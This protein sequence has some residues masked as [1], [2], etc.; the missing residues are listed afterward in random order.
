VIEHRAA[1]DRA[2][3][4]FQRRRKN[5][6]TPERCTHL[7]EYIYDEIDERPVIYVAGEPLGEYA[8]GRVES[9]VIE[10]DAEE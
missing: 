2:I 1:V 7:A 10:P 4:R 9:L 5:N 8:L 6:P 3:R